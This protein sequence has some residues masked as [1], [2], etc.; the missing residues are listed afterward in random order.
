MRGIVIMALTAVLV[1]MPASAVAGSYSVVSCQAADGVNNSWAF[2]YSGAA[3]RIDSG[4]G[5]GGAS[6]SEY[7]GLYARDNLAVNSSTNTVKG[8]WTFRAPPTTSVRGMTYS[9]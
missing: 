4:D 5:C 7:S 6:V 1:A 9:R 8:W 3:D 2:V